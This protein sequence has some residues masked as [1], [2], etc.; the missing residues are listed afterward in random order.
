MRTITLLA[1]A[2]LLVLGSCAEKDKTVSF[3]IEDL[4]KYPN[5]E[6][7]ASAAG[8]TVERLGLYNSG[9][10][11][12]NDTTA[13]MMETHWENYDKPVT[14]IR[15]EASARTRHPNKNAK[16]PDAWRTRDGVY[17]WITIDSLQAINGKPFFLEFD[18]NY[19]VVVNWEEGRLAKSGIDM[20]MTVEEGVKP[21][22]YM[23]SQRIIDKKMK[24]RGYKMEVWNKGWTMKNRSASN[25]IPGDYALGS[26]R[27]MTKSD[28]NLLNLAGL[29]LMRNEIF[30]RHGYMFNDDMLKEYFRREPWYRPRFT[31]VTDKLSSIE[32]KN[33]SLIVAR[34]NELYLSRPITAMMK[35]LPVLTL[36]LNLESQFATGVKIPNNIEDP[37]GDVMAETYWA[38]YAQQELYGIL[39]DTSR[40]YAVVW[41]SLGAGMLAGATTTFCV[42]TFD[43]KFKRISSAPLSVR[44]DPSA[45]STGE[46]N[47]DKHYESVV[48]E[49]LSFSS[50]YE[51]YI[52]CPDPDEEE[53]ESETEQ[54]GDE[55]PDEVA[56]VKGKI[57]K[58]GKVS[59]KVE[60]GY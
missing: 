3:P 39:P 53:S 31:D 48:N 59:V 40:Y 58:D 14:S 4:F 46:C 45:H 5:I 42:T 26:A 34:E 16:L 52:N 57:G 51:V 55:G 12:V 18:G 47:S 36:P 27:E 54:P 28:V 21:D 19:L 41:S 30:A 2:A 13:L 56:T 50:R 15:F 33:I 6:Q 37:D 29:R 11:M 23:S 22:G 25:G 32:R 1:F 49:D 60:G 35:T 24:V 20:F 17:A 8:D 10:I 43:K 38:E 7:L 44:H 9:W